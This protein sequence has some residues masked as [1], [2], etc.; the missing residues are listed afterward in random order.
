M[1]SVVKL[2]PAKAVESPCLLKVIAPAHEPVRHLG[3]VPGFDRVDIAQI[4][5]DLVQHGIHL[6][7]QTCRAG[8]Q[9]AP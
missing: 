3:H 2:G 6:G 8:R 7:V 5:L 9:Q 1:A 4:L